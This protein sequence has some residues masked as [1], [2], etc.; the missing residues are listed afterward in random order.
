MENEQKMNQI[1]LKLAEKQFSQLDQ[2]SEELGG[3]SKS[4]LIKVAISEFIIK[5]SDN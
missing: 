1:N 2:L 5:Y 3:V 4:N